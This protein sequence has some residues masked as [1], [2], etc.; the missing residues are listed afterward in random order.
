[1][2]ENG[3]AL[4]NEGHI[5][6]RG[7][8][9]H[10]AEIRAEGWTVPS[11]CKRVWLSCEDQGVVESRRHVAGIAAIQRFDKSGEQGVDSTP[12]AKLA[13]VVPA[14]GKYLALATQCEGMVT[15]CSHADNA[16]SSEGGDTHGASAALP[17]PNAELSVVV[18]PECPHFPRLSQS[19]TVVVAAHD[20]ATD[21][22]R[23]GG[24]AERWTIEWRQ[25][26][27]YSKLAVVILSKGVHPPSLGGTEG[28]VLS[29][30]YRSH[31]SAAE[32]LNLKR[33]VPVHVVSGS[34]LTSIV[35]PESPARAVVAADNRVVVGAA[36]LQHSAPKESV[37]EH[38][39]H[40]RGRVPVPELP[41]RVVAACEELAE[42]C[43]CALVLAPIRGMDHHH[44]FPLEV[45]NFCEL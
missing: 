21:N 26:R 36:D 19:Y 14:K 39:P 12:C 11:V 45:C 3:L 17:A 43:H 27:R 25:R 24:Q 44:P 35:A 28:V 33:R 15:A 37:H 7:V 1:M 23:Q 18:P 34:Q 30:G 16:V 41:P 5:G 32:L 31:L 20:L 13:M 42:L 4:D 40:D 22:V 38:G 10:L 6:S 8:V 2:R 29:A 9:Q